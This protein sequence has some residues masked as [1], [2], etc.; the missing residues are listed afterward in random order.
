M[1]ADADPSANPARFGH[2]LKQISVA[3]T[4]SERNTALTGTNGIKL[5]ESAVRSAI[6]TTAQNGADLPNQPPGFGLPPAPAAAN[7]FGMNGSG[8]PFGDHAATPLLPG[9]QTQTQQQQQQL[10]QGD[11]VQ[12]AGEVGVEGANANIFDAPGLAG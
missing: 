8:P 3:V 12:P 9:V 11:Q 5:E 4:E 7:G 2:L 1:R 10:Q 6:T